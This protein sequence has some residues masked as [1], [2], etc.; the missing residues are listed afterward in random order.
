[1]KT[2]NGLLIIALFFLL[3]CKK[4]TLEGDLNVLQGQYKWIGY[5]YKE[6]A[7]CSTKFSSSAGED[8]TAKIKFDNSGKIDF[9]INDES[10]VKQRF[11]ISK[12]DFNNGEFISLDIKVDV[13]KAKLDIN[14]KLT[15]I[16]VSTDTI[17][18]GGYPIPG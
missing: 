15:V 4:E 17:I 1:M 14:D 9:I 3:S 6:C 7:L 13:P 5:Q 18:V 10:Y 11:K 2:G 16:M 12:Q 8:Y